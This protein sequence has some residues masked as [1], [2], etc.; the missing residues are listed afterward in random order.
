[1]TVAALR[2]VTGFTISTTPL[3]LHA[4]MFYD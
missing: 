4:Q 3:F 1:M 2:V